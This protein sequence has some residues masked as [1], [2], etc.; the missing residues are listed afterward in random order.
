VY[1]DLR[2]AQPRWPHV[3]ANVALDHSVLPVPDASDFEPDAEVEKLM[4]AA[5][6]NSHGHRDATMVLVASDCEGRRLGVAWA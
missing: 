5:Q 4:H 2:G 6:G 3:V 1:S